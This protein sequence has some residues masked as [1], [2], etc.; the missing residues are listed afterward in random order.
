[1]VAKHGRKKNYCSVCRVDYEDYM[2][3]SNMGLSTSTISV[4]AVS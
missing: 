2:L 1:M 3:V 4:T